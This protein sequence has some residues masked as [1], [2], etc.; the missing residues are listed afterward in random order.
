MGRQWNE[1]QLFS[2]INL[3][4]GLDGWVEYN[5]FLINACTVLATGEN[6]A[7]CWICYPKPGGFLWK[8]LKLEPTSLAKLIAAGFKFLHSPALHLPLFKSH[9]GMETPLCFCLEPLS[10]KT[11]NYTTTSL[12]CNRTMGCTPCYNETN[13]RATD[14]FGGLASLTSTSSL[15]SLTEK[16]IFKPLNWSNIVYNPNYDPNCTLNNTHSCFDKTYSIQENDTS[17]CTS[18]K[19]GKPFQ[20]VLSKFSQPPCRATYLRPKI[21]PL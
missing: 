15:N 4:S 21:R 13:V 11:F 7:R 2:R 5:N 12:I 20:G 18:W 1:I 10:L 14:I 19:F 8:T 17:K 9:V 6:L 3:L 16:S